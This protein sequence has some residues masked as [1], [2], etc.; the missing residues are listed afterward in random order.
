MISKVLLDQEL[1]PFCGN[2]LMKKKK[3]V[4]VPVGDQC[5]DPYECRYYAYCHDKS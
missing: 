2:K 4:N 5:C 1:G 3:E